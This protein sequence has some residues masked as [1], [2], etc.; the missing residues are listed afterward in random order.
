MPTVLIIK[1]FTKSKLNLDIIKRA[2]IFWR[3]L[4]KIIPVVF[5]FI[6]NL[7][8]QKWNG[9]RPSFTANTKTK[10]KITY[11]DLLVNWNKITNIN[12]KTE[13]TL[14]T[15]KYFLVL[16]DLKWLNECNKIIKPTVFNSIINHKT[17]N[18]EELSN[19]TTDAKENKTPT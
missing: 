3:V 18:F 12:K 11:W 7:N 17:K 6:I 19:R 14:W 13:L 1:I 15:I 5:K 9:G 4:N 10:K 8:T 16:S 2:G